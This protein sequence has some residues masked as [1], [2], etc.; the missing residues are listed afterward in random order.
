MAKRVLIADD[1]DASRNSL[2]F[3]LSTKKF[4][5][6]QAKNGREALEILTAEPVG[7]I[8][9]IITDINMPELTGLQMIKKIRA[10]NDFKFIPILVI[11]SEEEEIK[12]SIAIGATAWILKSS[13]TSETLMATIEKII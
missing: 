4:Q 9:L 3:I 11:S 1:S 7:S 12:T 13:K 8:D 10:L 6:I 5:V 2:A